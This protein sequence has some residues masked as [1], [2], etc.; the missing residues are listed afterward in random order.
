MARAARRKQQLLRKGGSDQSA[1]A[2]TGVLTD[3]TP[4]ARVTL[5]GKC[6]TLTGDGEPEAG[7]YTLISKTNGQSDT[8]MYPKN[9]GDCG[10][11]TIVCF[12]VI[13]RKIANSELTLAPGASV[14]RYDS[15]RTTDS[16]QFYCKHASGTTCKLEFDR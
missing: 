9:A 4:P 11:L 10:P 14:R 13:G 7:D 15:A 16:I 2:R 8:I 5:D 12:N 3:P 1:Q 6:V